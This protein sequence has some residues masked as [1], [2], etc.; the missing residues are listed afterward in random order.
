ML[1]ALRT[2]VLQAAPNS[3]PVA[4]S[5]TLIV[6]LLAVLETLLSVSVRQRQLPCK[7]ERLAVDLLTRTRPLPV[8]F[9]FY[10]F[11]IPLCGLG[12]EN[13]LC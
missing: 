9:Y 8:S 10:L 7:L 2:S 5:A 6:H 13:E 3:S 12:C 11:K 1:L 4:V